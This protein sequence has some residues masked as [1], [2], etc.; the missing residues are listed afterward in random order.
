VLETEYIEAPSNGTRPALHLKAGTWLEKRSA[1]ERLD[2]LCHR[3]GPDV[4]RELFEKYR[5]DAQLALHHDALTI[6][7]ARELAQDPLVTIGAHGV[8][9]QRLSRMSAQQAREDICDS[10]RLLN[11][12]L[13]V[14]VRHLAYPY[15]G[16]DACE[17]REFGFARE[18]GFSSAVTTRRGNIFPEHVEYKWCLP[19]RNVPLN[20]TGLRNALS[21]VESVFR[22]EPV[23]RTA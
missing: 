11:E 23:F 19:R 15:G 16:P 1:L 8:T 21:G 13:G 22:R 20:V 2:A 6:E 7:Q 14:E 12:C 4:A 3:E 5:V 18:A 10:G 17:E 9:H